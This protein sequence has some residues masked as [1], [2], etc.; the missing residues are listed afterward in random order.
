MRAVKKDPDDYLIRLCASP[1][2]MPAREWNELLSA[3]DAPTPFMR[4]EY[5][6]ALHDS[7]SATGKTGWGVS[8]VGLWRGDVLQAACALWLKDHSYG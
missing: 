6:A 8:L 4:H 1:A 7:G 3:Q 5:L 2:E